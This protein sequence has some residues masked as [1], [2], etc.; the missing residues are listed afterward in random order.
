M[1]TRGPTPGVKSKDFP[2]KVLG[3]VAPYGVY[4]PTVNEGW[5]HV[6]ITHDTAEFAVE[7][8]RRWWSRMGHQV[9]PEASE[10]LVTAD[11]GGSNGS[12][13]RLWK[14]CLQELAEEL[15]LKIHVCP[16]P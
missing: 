6:G 12:R 8:I 16:F 10:S 13:S 15:G 5:V 3:K 2:D 4:D 7:S 14:V 9:S 1:G 11:S